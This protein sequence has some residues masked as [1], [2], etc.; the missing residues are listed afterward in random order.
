MLLTSLEKASDTITYGPFTRRHIDADF[1]DCS[2]YITANDTTSVR[3]R[4][5]CD[6]EGID[7]IKRNRMNPDSFSK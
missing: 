2:Y 3:C 6:V 7:W 4:R 1:I 5:M